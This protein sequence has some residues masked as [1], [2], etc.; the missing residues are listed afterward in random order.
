MRQLL[1]K[2][3]SLQHIAF[4]HDVAGF[5]RDLAQQVSEA[6]GRPSSSLTGC[7]SMYSPLKPNST[8]C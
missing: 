5:I 7:A 4:S 3:P 1:V 6:S 2:I 8:L